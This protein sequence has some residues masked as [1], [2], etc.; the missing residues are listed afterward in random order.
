M[1]ACSSAAVPI[2]SAMPLFPLRVLVQDWAAEKR[3]PQTSSLHSRCNALLKSF[4]KYS[5]KALFADLSGLIVEGLSVL[6]QDDYMGD[7]SGVILPQEV[8]LLSRLLPIQI[9]DD[10]LNATPVVLI[11]VNR[12]PRLSLGV[13]TPFAIDDDVVQLLRSDPSLHIVSS[14]KRTVD[15]VASVVKMRIQ[16]QIIRAKG[17]RQPHN[18]QPSEARHG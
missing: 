1:N 15:A 4:V 12:A 10:E 14:N 11:Q 9:Y 13:E 7:R 5:A 6:I 2:V 17:G 3:R 16:L 18:S 8:L